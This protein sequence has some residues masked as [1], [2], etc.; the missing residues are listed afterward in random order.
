LQLHFEVLSCG[1]SSPAH[2]AMVGR[3]MTKDFVSTDRFV[4]RDIWAA[5]FCST[6]GTI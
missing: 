6:N 5:L 4:A 3:K 2:E 1:F